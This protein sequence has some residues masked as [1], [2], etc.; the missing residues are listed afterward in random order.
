[1]RENE[2]D[3]TATAF[4]VTNKDE[5]WHRASIPSLPSEKY[6][7]EISADSQELGLPLALYAHHAVEHGTTPG[8]TQS[9]KVCLKIP[10]IHY[11]HLTRFIQSETNC[12]GLNQVQI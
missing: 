9:N 10:F 6:Y 7:E 11:Y 1:M 2:V 4:N 12:S 5:V 8:S 3:T